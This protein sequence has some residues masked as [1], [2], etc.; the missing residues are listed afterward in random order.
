[1]CECMTCACMRVWSGIDDPKIVE[2]E[3]WQL[4]TS[5]LIN[6][7][8]RVRMAFASQAKQNGD[9]VYANMLSLGQKDEK[10]EQETKMRK[11]L[12]GYCLVISWFDNL[13]L[14]EFSGI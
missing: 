2:N 8:I 10:S 12:Q 3:D 6:T 11:S 7:Y 13:Q 4:P 14:Y 5:H 1:M 9:A